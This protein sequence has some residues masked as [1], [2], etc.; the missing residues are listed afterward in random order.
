MNGAASDRD[1]HLLLGWP[2]ASESARAQCMCRDTTPLR[3]VCQSLSQGGLRPKS[4]RGAERTLTPPSP[5]RGRGCADVERRFGEG[6]AFW[7]HFGGIAPGTQRRPSRFSGFRRNFLE[8]GHTQRWYGT[9]RDCR[10]YGSHGSPPGARNDFRFGLFAVQ[11]R[12]PERGG[13]GPNGRALAGWG[14][15]S[16]L[17][18]RLSD[19]KCATFWGCLPILDV[20]TGFFGQGM[21][22]LSQRDPSPPTPLPVRW[23]RG[24]SS[25]EVV[26]SGD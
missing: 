5:V 12:G 1:R 23:E 3:T 14:N 17:K 2:V 11:T 16:T 20:R 10:G 18:E 19:K 22:R 6:A 4:D 25:R 9:R 21:R 26:L 8:L 15:S 7:A 13:A 24:A